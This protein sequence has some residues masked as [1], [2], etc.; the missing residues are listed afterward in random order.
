MCNQVISVKTYFHH[1]WLIITSTDFGSFHSTF[2]QFRI[3]FMALT[4]SRIMLWLSRNLSLRWVFSHK[5][6]NL[7]PWI[8]Q[9]WM[10][11]LS[12]S[13]LLLL[14]RLD[15]VTSTDLVELS[16]DIC[17]RCVKISAVEFAVAVVEFV[18]AVVEYELVSLAW[19]SYSV[20]ISV[21]F[22]FWLVVVC[23]IGEYVRQKTRDESLDHSFFSCYQQSIIP[24][25]KQNMCVDFNAIWS[26]YR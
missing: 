14:F 7:K 1:C 2:H 22:H 3:F 20:W 15:L 5:M 11:N 18:V 21:S 17:G 24:D 10:W 13:W 6:D 16:Q 12:E 23:A 26:Q 19:W 4:E 9:H 8:Y 25:A